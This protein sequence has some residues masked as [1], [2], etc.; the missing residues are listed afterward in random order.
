M[1]QATTTPVS[2]PSTG[3]SFTDAGEGP[4]VLLVHGH[5]FDR[6]MWLPQIESLTA[7]G[8]RA[9][10]PDL[11]GYG[12]SLSTDRV[13]PMSRFAAD[14]L[15]LLDRLEIAKA[16]VVG[17]SMGGL[18][19]M[20]FAH[21]TPQR[22]WALGLVATTAEPVTELEARQRL[23]I[24]EAA[25]AEGVGPLVRSMSEHLYGPRCPSE[26]VDLVT[27]MMSQ[28]NPVGAAA[29]LRGRA[30]RPDY[31]VWLGEVTVPT[32]V[33]VGTADHWSTSDVTTQLLACLVD[34]TVEILQ[35]VGHLP[36]LE[37]PSHFNRAL[38]AFLNRARLPSS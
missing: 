21:A 19:A 9:V 8:F 38:I 22:L 36:N 10:A 6:R 11:R 16:A 29:A 12:Q 26:V 2:S 33:C 27:S 4:A 34:P 1:R 37:T 24:A 7:A 30:Q 32:F 31:R 20:E 15:G 14:L 28:S 23:A 25:E 18:V 13:T 35:D 5:P 3:L 17:L